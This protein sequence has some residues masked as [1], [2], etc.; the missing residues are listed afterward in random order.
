MHANCL[1][2]KKGLIK[3]NSIV[4]RKRAF[5]ELSFVVYNHKIDVHT[6]LKLCIIKFGESCQVFL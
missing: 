4:L 1:C 5:V 2:F 6:N 3:E